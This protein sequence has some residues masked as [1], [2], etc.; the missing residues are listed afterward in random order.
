MQIKISDIAYY[1]PKKLVTNADYHK[2]NSHWDMSLVEKKV[3]VSSRYI[4]EDNETALDIAHKACLKLFSTHTGLENKIDAL[5]FCTQSNDYIMPSNACILHGQLGLSEKVI[6][7]DFNLACSGFVYGLTIAQGFILAGQ[8]S[9]VLLVTADTYSK[10]IHKQDRSVR[11]L[12]GDGGAI[13]WITASETT[14]GMHDV[15][16]A[17]AGAHYEKFMISA[18]GCRMPKS[19][20]TAITTKDDSGNIRSLENIRMDGIGVLSFINA[21]VPLQVKEVLAANS[22]GIDDIKLFLFHQASKMTLDSLT[23]LLK[24][25]PEQTY[26]NLNKVGNLVSASI[27]V[28]LKNALEEGLLQKGDKVIISGFGVGLSWASALYEI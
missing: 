17:T 1:L 23:R 9:N 20:E 14:Q 22:L 16:C 12:F 18:G 6:A 10:Y 8:A 27:P 28:L 5:I 11:V 21:K 19:P 15:T 25:R 4:A 24:L 7:F 13:T 2:E 3:G 26:Q